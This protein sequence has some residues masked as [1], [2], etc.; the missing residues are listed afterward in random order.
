MLNLEVKDPDLM[1]RMA[2]PVQ[3]ANQLNTSIYPNPTTGIIQLTNIGDAL[4][5]VSDVSGRNILHL[6]Y[7]QTLNLEHFENGIYYITITS[8]SGVITRSKILLN[9]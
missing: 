9:K 3:K 1:L 4:I 7:K 6:R 8:S 5:D 2:N